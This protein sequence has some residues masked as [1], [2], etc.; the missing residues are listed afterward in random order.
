MIRSQHFTFHIE[1]AVALGEQEVVILRAF[2]NC[3]RS[4]M[5]KNK[6]KVLGGLLCITLLP[7]D[8]RELGVRLDQENNGHAF[9]KCAEEMLLDVFGALVVAISNIAVNK[10]N[11]ELLDQGVT[12]RLES[13]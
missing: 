8:H 2:R 10:L 5:F 3:P 1:F 12:D 9:A 4:M 13:L 6:D 11:P 7:I